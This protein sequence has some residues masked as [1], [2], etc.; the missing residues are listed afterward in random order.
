MFI[1]N[2]YSYRI[3]HNGRMRGGNLGQPKGK[4]L[5]GEARNF[6][7]WFTQTLD[8]FD[9]G[10][11]ATWQQRYYVNDDFISS[12]RNV[13]F[14]MIG[15]EGEATDV[16]MTNG[17]WTNYGKNLSAILFQLEHRYY[18]KS[19]PTEDLS[20]E[21]LKFLTSQQ[22]LADIAAFITETN[23]EFNLAP[24]VKWIVFGGSYPGSLAAW[25]RLK[26][27][28]LIHGAVSTSGPLLAIADFQDY[29]QVVA[30]DLRGISEECYLAVKKGTAQIDTFLQHMVGQRTLSKLFQLCDPIENS[31]NNK[32]DIAN[33]YDH[34]AGNFAGIAQYNK[35]N[36]LSTKGTKLG[37]ITLDTV[38]DIMTNETE[39]SEITRL[40]HFNSLMLNATNDTCLDFKYSNMI[41]DMRNFSW[42]GPEAEG[43]RQWTFQTCNEFGF[44]QTSSKK[45]QIFGTMFPVEFYLQQCAD[46][47]GSE[48]NASYVNRA[49][50][51][52]NINY[53]ALDI[54]VTNVVFV[55]GSVDPWHALG[56]TQSDNEDAPTIYIKGTAHCANMYPPSDDDLPQLQAARAQIL[57]YITKWLQA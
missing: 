2:C 24:D 44:Y 7:R 37:N 40:A 45:P 35:D 43:G 47:Y 16:W 21:N 33:L 49:V 18:G 10:N 30:D 39:K 52:T 41:R 3:F 9:I 15:G 25:A 51:F 23:R 55:H 42:E 12:S 26:Y 19:H 1:N 14:L 36:R 8:H 13:A 28:H 11:L 32:N 48:F 20:V 4:T 38:C 6:T 34:L 31:I 50:E 57:E 54:K 27:P 46:V 17:A 29:F 5:H 22:A 53:G 56:I